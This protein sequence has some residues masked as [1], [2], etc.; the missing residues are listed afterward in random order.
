VSEVP[1]RSWASRV[2]STAGALAF[3]SAAAFAEIYACAGSSVRVFADDA[4]S[5]D[6]PVREIQGV[7]T[8][9][10][11]CYGIALDN[12]HNELWVSTQDSVSVFRATDSGNLAPLRAIRGNLTGIGFAVS[13]AV[14]LE[15]DEVLVGSAFGGIF[16]FPRSG[17]GNIAPL[18]TI[19]G[20]STDLT[21]VGGLFVDQVNDELYA[22]DFF[23]STPE[24][25]VFARQAAGDVPPLR[26]IAGFP[27]QNPVGLFVDSRANEVYV[28]V[29]QPAI[30]VYDLAGTFFFSIQ[31]PSTQL[32]VTTG[33]TMDQDGMLLVGNENP[34]PASPDPMLGF[35]R[36]PPGDRPPTFQISSAAPGGR[37]LWGIA[38]SRAFACGEGNTTSRCLFRH[39]F[40]GGNVADWSA[41][42]G[43]VP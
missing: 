22:A 8:G 3:L 39:S 28:S 32:G 13:V 34:A 19:Q 29:G 42:N 38:S 14:D 16:A 21:N 23:S 17:N 41:S 5:G 35:Q 33:L 40:E 26:Q 18:R 7:A 2:A 12:W 27:G 9:I 36:Y 37:P 15:A 11:E 1:D 4:L 31:G 24:V 6:P 43:L 20:P 10:T 25:V 30:W